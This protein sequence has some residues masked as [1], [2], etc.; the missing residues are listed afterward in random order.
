M[1]RKKT[2]RPARLAIV[3]L[4]LTVTSPPAFGG[5]RLDGH[6]QFAITIPL[7]PGAE[8]TRTF[9]ATLD[10][11][12]RGDSLQGRMTITDEDGRTVGGVWRQV[13]KKV[14]IAYELPCTPGSPCASLIMLGTVK[15][16]GT[17][18]KK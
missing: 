13:N 1:Q 14:S 17:L 16:G 4:L 9:S 3:L 6:W 8:A 5:K 15:S 18:I 10:V 2:A 7:S 11:E 12:P